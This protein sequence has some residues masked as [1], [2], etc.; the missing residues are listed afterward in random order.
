MEEGEDQLTSF[1]KICR[2]CLSKKTNEML[3]P[4]SDNRL[5]EMLYSLTTIEVIICVF[6]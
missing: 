6:M 3:K 2:T 1:D 4:L 5:H